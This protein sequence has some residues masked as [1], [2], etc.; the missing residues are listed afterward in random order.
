MASSMSLLLA[1][2]IVSTVSWAGSERSC[3]PWVPLESKALNRLVTCE[4]EPVQRQVGQV[5]LRHEWRCGD[6]PFGQ[7]LASWLAEMHEPIAMAMQGDQLVFSGQFGADHLALFWKVR[8]EDK[9]GFQVLVSRIRPV[10]KL[11]K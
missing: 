11:E 7:W 4:D 3:M 9:P 6:E 1:L 5:C 8:P 2:C 10:N